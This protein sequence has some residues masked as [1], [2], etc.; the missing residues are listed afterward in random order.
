MQLGLYDTKAGFFDFINLSTIAARRLYGKMDAKKVGGV[1]YIDDIPWFK[2]FTWE[3]R[4]YC[5][6]LFTV[7]FEAGIHVSNR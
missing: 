7:V 6:Y 2:H 1:W 3:S 4:I 5:A